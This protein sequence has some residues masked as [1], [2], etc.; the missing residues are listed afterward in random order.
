MTRWANVEEMFEVLRQQD[1]HY[2]IRGKGESL[3]PFEVLAYAWPW[4]TTFNELSRLTGLNHYDIESLI[5]NGNELG[6]W[7]Y[8]QVVNRGL[9]AEDVVQAVEKLQRNAEVRREHGE[10]W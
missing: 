6:E 8:E 1:E 10:D 2:R 9:T 4:L 5:C 3:T 7:P